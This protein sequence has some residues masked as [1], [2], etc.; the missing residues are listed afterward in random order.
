MIITIGGA[1]EFNDSELALKEIDVTLKQ[2]KKK[3]KDIKII[4]GIG[5]TKNAG[6]GG[7]FFAQKW[8]N[9]NGVTFRDGTPKFREHGKFAVEKRNRILAE[10]SD[11]FILLTK[12]TSTGGNG[13]ISKF[14]ECGVPIYKIAQ[15][16]VIKNAEEARKIFGGQAKLLLETSVTL[17]VETTG[18]SETDDDIVEIAVVDAKNGKTLYNSFVFTETPVNEHAFAVNGITLDMISA[19]PSFKNVW[20][21][22]KAIIENKIV[23]ASNS[24]FDE[25]MVC[26]GALKNGLTPP[27]NTWVC[28]Q[29]LYCKYAGIKATKIKTEKMARQLGI[30]PGTHRALVDAQAQAKILKAMAK[31]IEPNLEID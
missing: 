18:L 10:N 28:L 9:D 4:Y 17:D 7:Y 29:R 22:I 23:V 25:K 27:Q 30:E 15:K 24:D 20:K 14:E 3:P 5:E 31:G 26:Y 1:P 21:D 8:A 11:A 2:L 16:E 6:E 12:G 19:S 13:I